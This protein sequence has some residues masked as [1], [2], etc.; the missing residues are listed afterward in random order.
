MKSF[1]LAIFIFLFIFSLENTAS[2]QLSG[3]QY[4]AL[5]E[6]AKNEKI[7]KLEK[8]K[9]QKTK[10]SQF[11]D[12][13]HKNGNKQTKEQFAAL[14]EKAKNEKISK[15]EEIK[16]N[17][18]KRSQQTKVDKNKKVNKITKEQFVILMKNAKNAKIA[19]IERYKAKKSEK[20]RD[21]SINIE[22]RSSTNDA[23][24]LGENCGGIGGKFCEIGLDC[25]NV[26]G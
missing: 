26:S 13:T 15:L 6:N 20:E 9:A 19:Q 23:S 4:A 10:G 1:I 7:A 12:A 22:K 11:H 16:T 24:A 21:F 2:A 8:L 3:E 14:M 5:M 17:I 18:I 25:I